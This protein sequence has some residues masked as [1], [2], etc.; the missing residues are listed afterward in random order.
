MGYARQVT[1][2]DFQSEEQ[3]AFSGNFL[4]RAG[5]NTLLKQYGVKQVYEA[6]VQKMT[7]E[8]LYYIDQNGE[9]CFIEADTIVSAF[10][11]RPRAQVADA[12][13]DLVLETY[14]IGDAARVGNVM[15]ANQK[16]FEI[17]WEI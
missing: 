17:S 6:R 12:L 14:V 2:I 7:E 1:L 4:L 11:M 8:G 9:T 16:A 15:S 3:L 10:G 13:K 5:V